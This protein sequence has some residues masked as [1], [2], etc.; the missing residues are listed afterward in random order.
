MNPSGPKAGIRAIVPAA[1]AGQRMGRFK[2]VLPYRGSTLVGTVTGTLLDAGVDGIVVVT[3]T[4]LVD[5]LALPEDPRVVIAFNDDPDS[6]MIDSI[7]V[8]LA[9]LAGETLDAGE[10]G[11]ADRSGE[12]PADSAPPPVAARHLASSADGVLVVPG[13][14][15]TLSAG[16]CRQCMAAYAADPRRIVIATHAARRGHPIIFPFSMRGV[17][18]ELSGG[19]RELPARH[20]ERVHLVETDDAGITRDINTLGEYERLW[21]PRLDTQ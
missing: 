10:S 15:P 9:K 7:R 11:I 14:M 13:D 12:P 20:P 21:N 2:Q 8:G 6:E 4:P 18:D 19:L 1:G 3:R 16:T 17:V 5:A